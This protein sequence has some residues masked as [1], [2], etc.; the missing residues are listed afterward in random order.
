[1]S[2]NKILTDILEHKNHFGNLLEE[3]KQLSNRVK[4]MTPDF[5]R[6]SYDKSWQTL[7][8][9]EAEVERTI[10][11]IDNSI[12]YLEECK[13][14]LI[15]I[16]SFYE[17]IKNDFNTSM[18]GPLAARALGKVKEYNLPAES[19]EQQFVM[20]LPYNEREETIRHN[21]G[22]KKVNRK[23]KRRRR[24]RVSKNSKQK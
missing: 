18:T 17:E 2:I 11:T 9:K 13:K 22:G 19:G 1:M 7:Q 21:M 12:T 4:N 24:R 8:N 6:K 14:I 3:A 23:T 5:K 10:N 20:D 16:N 15:E